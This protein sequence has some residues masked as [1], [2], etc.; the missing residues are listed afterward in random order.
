LLSYF[1]V[2]S[3]EGVKGGVCMNSG[4]LGVAIEVEEGFA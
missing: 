2:T 1:I 4:V 3:G